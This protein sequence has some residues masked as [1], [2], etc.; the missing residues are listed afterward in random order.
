M[1]SRGSSGVL[2]GLEDDEPSQPWPSAPSAIASDDVAGVGKLTSGVGSLFSSGR[3]GAFSLFSPD[4]FKCFSEPTFGKLVT[5]FRM[6]FAESRGFTGEA[7]A[8]IFGSRDMTSYQV[9]SRNS[10]CRGQ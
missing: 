6:L 5:T 9:R 10:K 8:Q 2:G 1:V 7:L 4:S 3:K